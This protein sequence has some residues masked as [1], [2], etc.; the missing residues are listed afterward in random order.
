MRAAAAQ[1]DADGLPV[2][3]GDVEP[4]DVSRRC[5][6][7]LD[8]VRPGEVAAGR[9]VELVP[10]AP[11]VGDRELIERDQAGVVMAQLNL[12]RRGMYLPRRDE[13]R[14]RAGLRE[15]HEAQFAADGTR[16]E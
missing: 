16:E 8:H 2:R 3:R 4:A 9:V 11:V 5:G 7:K 13:P 12:Q 15:R 6:A 10:G 1:G 14:A